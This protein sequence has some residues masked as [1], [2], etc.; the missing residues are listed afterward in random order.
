MGW[1]NHLSVRYKILLIPVVGTLGFCCF[2]WLSSV[3]NHQATQ[4]LAQ[5]RDVYFPLLEIAN[6]NQVRLD[7]TIGKMNDAVTMGE[8]DILKEAASLNEQ[9]LKAF[10]QQKEL[11][12][13]KKSEID[14]TEKSYSDFYSAAYKV[15]E[16]M[17]GGSASVAAMAGDIQA[18]NSLQQSAEK[19]LKDFRENS[20]SQFVD[21]VKAS[22]DASKSTLY[23]NLVIGAV[24]IAVLLVTALVVAATITGN[25]GRVV[26]SLKDIAQG[27]GDLTRRISVS[28]QDE[29]GELV[30][31]FNTFVEKLQKSLVD[32]VGVIEPLSKVSQELK[33]VSAQTNQDSIAQS[34]NA[35]IVSQSMQDLIVSFKDMAGRAQATAEAAVDTDQESQQG[36]QIVASTVTSINELAVEVDEAAAVIQQLEKDAEN[37]GGIL[38]VIRGIAEQTNL[39]ALNAAIEAARAG[40]QG[41]G[42]AVVADEVRTLASRTQDA[43]REIRTVIEQLQGAAG[44]AVTVMDHSKRCASQSV[45]HASKTGDSLLTITGKVATISEMNHQI[46]Q[47]TQKQQSNS[48]VISEKVAHMRD[49]ADQTRR[50]TEN[51]AGLSRSLEDFADKLYRVARQFKV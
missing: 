49:V 45:Q 26:D 48:T 19:S 15:S 6:A 10:A 1:F 14:Q 21:L 28:S 8:K 41:R 46:A 44:K 50:S 38:D 29:V 30:R 23:M 5:I 12:P 22:E 24:T 31:W 18:K 39:L 7:L 2:L 33:G 36:Q 27:E 20:H 43:T 17:L 13:E 37:V 47:E 42:F 25:V 3:N 9:T 4:R 16:G 34:R 35:E 51:V 11:F 32:V 40:E